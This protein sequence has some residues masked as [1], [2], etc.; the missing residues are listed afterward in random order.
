MSGLNG[1]GRKG[2][3]VEG[4]GEGRP[5]TALALVAFVAAAPGGFEVLCGQRSIIGER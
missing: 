5:S 3:A 2:Q 4:A 1:S